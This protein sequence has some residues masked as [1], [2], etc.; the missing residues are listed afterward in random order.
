MPSVYRDAETEHFAV[1]TMSPLIYT[2]SADTIESQFGLNFLA[3]VE[4]T[5]KLLIQDAVEAVSQE[6]KQEQ[7]K[8]DDDVLILGLQ[9]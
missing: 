9:V 1:V 8:A 3:K 6:L 7:G 2:L 4:K 5:S